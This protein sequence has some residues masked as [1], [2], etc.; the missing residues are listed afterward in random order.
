M[1]HTHT[2]TKHFFSAAVSCRAITTTT[3]TMKRPTDMPLLFSFPPPRS[4]EKDLFQI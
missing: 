2:H 1:T 4:G 3:I